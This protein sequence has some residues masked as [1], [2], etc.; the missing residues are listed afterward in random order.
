MQSRIADQLFFLWHSLRHP[1]ITGSQLPSGYYLS[2]AMI[3]GVNPQTA[4]GIIELGP[5]TGPVTR[6][7]IAAGFPEDRICSIELSEEFVDKLQEKYPRMKIIKGS[8]FDVEEWQSQIP[9]KEVQAVIS[10]LPLMLFPPE[11]NFALIES[12]LFSKKLNANKMIQFSYF[13]RNPLR[14][15]PNTADYIQIEKI[16][17]IWRNLYPATVWRYSRHV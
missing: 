3:D 10:S 14:N 11:Q 6:Q 9:F 15:Q 13:G 1:K 17:F 5:G 2:K 12:V 4:G 16:N 7:L 8:A